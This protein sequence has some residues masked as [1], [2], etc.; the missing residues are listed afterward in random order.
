MTSPVKRRQVLKTVPAIAGVSLAGCLGGDDDPGDDAAPADDSSDDVSWP[1]DRNLVDLIHGSSPGGG[2]ALIAQAW[3]QWFQEDLPD[4]ISA[5]VSAMPGGGGVTGHNTVWN[6][7]PD[8]GTM[9]VSDFNTLLVNELTQPGDV[10]YTT[11]GF[12]N[13]AMLRFKTRAIQI[14]HHTQDIDGHWGWDWDTFI[15]NAP[16]MNFGAANPNI[17]LLFRMIEH[18]DERLD[19][20]DLNIINYSGG[21][22]V[23]SAVLTGDVDVFGG[24]YASNYRPERA[25]EYYYTCFVATDSRFPEFQEKAFEVDPDSVFFDETTLPQE[26]AEAIVNATLDAEAFHGPPDLP[27]EIRQMYEESIERGAPQDT[28]VAELMHDLV[29]PLDHNVITG[30]EVDQFAED[31][32]RTLSESEIVRDIFGLD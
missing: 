26:G 19:E 7:E 8:G 11:T 21:G 24:G 9:H 28:M 13:I 23:R 18:F 16:D 10:D 30:E 22:D 20:G 15:D 27:A 25:E 6:A 17:E 31:S 32:Y 4:N 2:P 5:S 14:S 12:Q 1:P 3:G 29:G